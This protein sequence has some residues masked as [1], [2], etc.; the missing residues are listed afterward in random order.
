M[1]SFTT[2]TQKG[3]VTIPAEMRLLLGIRPYGRV[4][5]Q[6]SD[7]FIKIKP[8]EDIL[9]MAGSVSPIK[10]RSALKSR[11]WMEKNYKRV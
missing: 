8:V 2:V 7:G 1:N 9:D 10:G 11:A 3:Q 6:V 4:G 5:L